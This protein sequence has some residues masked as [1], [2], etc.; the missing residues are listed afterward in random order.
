[1]SDESTDKAATSRIAAM[2]D[3]TPL[4]AE[5]HL[6]DLFAPST[7]H[8]RIAAELPRTE[9]DAVPDLTR[10]QVQ[11]LHNR[12]IRGA[13]AVRNFLRA[14]WHATNPPLPDLD[15]AIAR[16][17]Q[18]LDRHE[19]IIVYGDYDCDGITSCALLLSAL[20]SVGAHA[21][22]YIPL[23]DDDGRGLNLAAV[24]AFATRGATLLI[25][26]DCGSTNVAE[27]ALAHELGLDVIITDHH[28]LHGP[29]AAP[30]ALVNPWCAATPSSETDLVG[31]GV[32]FRLAEALLTELATATHP[33]LAA[34]RAH[35]DATLSTLLD[36]LAIGTVADV[37][38]LSVTNWA[39][40]Q[41]GLRR[42]NQA[43]RPGLRALIRTAGL[44]PGAVS[45]RDLSFGIAPRLNSSARL[46]QPMLAIALLVTEDATEAERLAA[47]LEV[48]NLE[49]QRST[50][51][52][53]LEARRQIE[54]QLRPSLADVTDTANAH[55]ANQPAVFIAQGDG[56]P[57]GLLGLV[58]GR[59]AD[60]YQRPAFVISRADGECRGS[61]RSARN[62]DLG[63]LLAERP[64]FF[65]RFGG[66]AQA[67]G[68][69]LLEADL[70]AFLTFLYQRFADPTTPADETATPDV[71]APASASEPHN[72]RTDMPRAIDC[73][74][75]LHRIVPDVANAIN[76]LAPFGH[77]F[78][79][80]T[81]ISHGVRLMRCWRTGVDGRNLRVVLREGRV[82]RVAL[83]AR[84]GHRYDELM[85][86]LPT[87]PPL[88]VVYSIDTYRNRTSDAIEVSPRILALAPSTARQ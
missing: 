77:G 31:V 8:W 29:L 3:A 57:L 72:Q 49:R 46:G 40:V 61:A 60:D 14:E 47:Q 27:T 58:A 19:Q 74:L 23:R 32:A 67:A 56:W 50:E 2:A 44:T 17:R 39:L 6:T 64:E 41:S 4:A 18:A 73:R 71:D 11:L 21:E 22:P 38:T 37:A 34:A 87:L 51:T 16:I 15:R 88:D 33:D 5:I 35:A 80:P 75:P 48:L 7:T 83:W 69:T 63:A 79:E 9:L 82:E 86:A 78:P 20:R 42:I 12:Q 13:E 85:R 1:M 24:R 45:A 28:P 30:V 52:M 10:L 25:T 54:Q 84:Q 43:P 59:I 81:F 55:S 65:R 62:V 26:T 66:H 70:P 36:L 53:L 68:F 76:A